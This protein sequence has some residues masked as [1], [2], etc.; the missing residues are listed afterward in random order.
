M[1]WLRTHFHKHCER[2]AWDFCWR[3]AIEGVVISFIAV[4]FLEIF[5]D[6]PS[7]DFINWPIPVMLAVVLILAPILETLL[8]QALP[9][10]IAKLCRAGLKI[11]ILVSVIIFGL[12]H[13]AEGAAV[14]IGAG[15]VGGFYLA[16]TYAHW[17]QKSLWKALWVTTAAHII[18][19]AFPAVVLVFAHV[20]EISLY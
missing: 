17:A 13:F 20:F 5:I 7:R 3:T 9:I 14:G 1:N 10:T 8:L 4:L 15:L 12:L 2:S 11:Q 19:N 16:F 6:V 18:R